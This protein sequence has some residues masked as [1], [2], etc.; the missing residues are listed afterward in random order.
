MTGIDD[1][2]DQMELH[3]SQVQ[4]E[5]NKIMDT[6]QKANEYVKYNVVQA[7]DTDQ[8]VLNMTAQGS[9][10]VITI[11]VEMQ[12]MLDQDSILIA[13]HDTTYQQG[14]RVIYNGLPQELQE[15]L[16]NY[17]NE[18]LLK[19]PLEIVNSI[20]RMHAVVQGGL[21]EL[22]NVIDGNLGEEEEKLPCFS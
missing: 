14:F 9:D 13:S 19:N 21:N 4:S 10:D 18:Q 2:C 15:Y 7:E 1:F 12:E 22:L 16:I 3:K 17:N 5:V 6:V 11:R 20:I 8:K